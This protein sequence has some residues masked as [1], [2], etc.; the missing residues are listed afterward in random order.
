M[1]QTDKTQSEIYRERILSMLDPT[2]TAWYLHEELKILLWYLHY[3]KLKNILNNIDL[4]LEYMNFLDRQ[5]AKQFEKLIQEYESPEDLTYQDLNYFVS[6][7][8]RKNIW[9]NTLLSVINNSQVQQNIQN[10]LLGIKGFLLLTANEF[11][12]ATSTRISLNRLER[13]R[14]EHKKNQRGSKH[15]VLEDKVW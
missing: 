3:Y 5:N 10:I 7:N 15:L 11:C 12:H 1:G 14:G 9:D 6:E 8:T 13:E 4:L 2:R